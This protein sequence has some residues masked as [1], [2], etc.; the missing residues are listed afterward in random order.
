MALS[1]ATV[2]ALRAAAARRF[3]GDDE[4]YRAWLAETFPRAE[5]KDADRPST[6][7][8]TEKEASRAIKLLNTNQPP[9]RRAYAGTG[10]VGYVKHLTQDQADEIGRLEADLGW[11]GTPRLLDFIKRQTGLNKHVAAL[12]LPEATAVITGLRRTLTWH[13]EQHP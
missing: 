2:K 12:T 9:K 6:L 4:L 3:A 7:D 11:V 1:T 5:W 13:E 8:L 10:Q